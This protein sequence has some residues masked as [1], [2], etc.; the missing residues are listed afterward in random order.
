MRPFAVGTSLRARLVLLGACVGAGSAV[1][2]V[3]AAWTGSVWGWLA[4]PL[5][6]ALGWLF[7]ADPT[8]CAGDGTPPR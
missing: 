3:V 4:V 7:V 2:G 5:A 1:G 6:I 8:R